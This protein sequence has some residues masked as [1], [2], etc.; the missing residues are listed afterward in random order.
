MDNSLDQTHIRISNNFDRSLLDFVVFLFNLYSDS[1]LAFI[2]S[3]GL[4]NTSQPL[5]REYLAA[6]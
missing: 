3:K 4:V 5:Q 2:L 6:P 1:R